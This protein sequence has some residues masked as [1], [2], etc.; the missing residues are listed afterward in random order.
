V[1]HPIEFVQGAASAR[2]VEQAA[3]V[4]RLHD[5]GRPLTEEDRKLVEDLAERADRQTPMCAPYSFSPSNTICPPCAA[6]GRCLKRHV[7]GGHAP[8]EGADK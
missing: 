7:A 4:V 8:T 6:F 3:R 5:T 2:S 1:S